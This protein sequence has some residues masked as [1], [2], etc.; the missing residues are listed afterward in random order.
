M[1]LAQA[2]E[3]QVPRLETP[4]LIL[5]APRLAD[6]DLFAAYI[7][8]ER[9]RYTG[10]PL[11]RNLAWRGFGHMV[12]H[13]VLRGYGFFVL[14]EK[15]TGKALGTTGPYFP[16]GWPEPEIGWTIWDASAEGKGLASEAALAA[17]AWAYEV[18]GW[19][20]AISLI[21]AGN[22]RSEALA[23]KLGCTPDG[24]FSHAQFGDSSIW[25]HP[26]PDAQGA[27]SEAYA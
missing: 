2:F 8:S 19:Q 20:T 22:T 4:R 9:S 15:A 24:T 18:L 5:R 14:E 6:F 12:G 25:R 23:Q 26:A 16:E 13:W 17:R 21:V 27:G 7:A 1:T 3:G 11:D 10:G